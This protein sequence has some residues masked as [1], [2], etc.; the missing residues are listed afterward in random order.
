M[1]C[2]EG[3]S[4]GLWGAMTCFEL[5]LLQKLYTPAPARLNVLIRKY[6]FLKSHKY[7]F[8]RAEEDGIHTKCPIKIDTLSA[9]C[10]NKQTKQEVIPMESKDAFTLANKTLTN[11]RNK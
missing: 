2:E 11:K 9:K 7:Q 3:G 10:K 6:I 8:W 5:P 4:W 1:I